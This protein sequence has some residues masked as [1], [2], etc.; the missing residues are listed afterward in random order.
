MLITE[1]DWLIRLIRLRSLY[2]HKM[3][4]SGFMDPAHHSLKLSPGGSVGVAGGM[5]GDSASVGS[6]LHANQFSATSNGYSMGMANGTHGGPHHPGQLPTHPHHPHAAAAS[7]ISSYAA[8]DFLIR[9]TAEQ[10]SLPSAHEAGAATAA[11]AAV[12]NMFGVPP[13]VSMAGF[14]H[15]HHPADPSSAASHVLFPGLSDSNH[16]PHHQ[17][18]PSGHQ[19]HLFPYHRAD[20]YNSS[21][22]GVTRATSDHHAF[23]SSAHPHHGSHPHL[24]PHLN[25][26][27]M[28]AAA[29]AHHAHR[30]NSMNMGPPG[31]G[32]F[33]PFMRHPI[34]QEHT[35]LWV[36]QDQPEPRKPCNKL[37]TTM[38][39]IVTHI[40]VEHVGGPEQANHAC[41]WQGCPRDGRPF[42]AK[43]KLVNHVR[44]HT[45]EKPFPCPFPGCGK[46]F[47]RSENLKIHKRTHTGRSR[48]RDD[49]FDS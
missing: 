44:V 25:P 40:T 14:H 2:L 4:I 29:A 46:V 9:R 35:C 31:A 45:G 24:P 13:S 23:G 26:M 16:H 32:A 38:H 41:Y 8:R 5:G 7:Q 28:S 18:V 43:Y 3:M 1:E 22:G 20:Q 12:N 48:S 27:N 34:K 6:S 19:N 15:P 30:M 39:E 11:A 33:Y 47:A 21:G 37:F 42:K 10:F 49:K 17:M 36:D